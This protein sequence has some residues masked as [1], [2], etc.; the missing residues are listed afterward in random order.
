MRDGR[1]RKEQGRER[2]EKEISG[3]ARRHDEGDGEWKAGERGQGKG[4]EEGKVRARGR[5]TECEG[6]G[7]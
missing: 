2:N 5:R 4:T 1:E 6:R 3:G 7:G